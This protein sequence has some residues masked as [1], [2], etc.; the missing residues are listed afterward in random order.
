MQPLGRHLPHGAWGRNFIHNI[1]L[2]PFD[3]YVEDVSVFTRMNKPLLYTEEFR[4]RLGGSDPSAQFREFAAHTRTGEP[5]DSLLY[6]DA[7]T[8]LPGD[9]LTKV[10]RMTMAVGLEARTPLLDHK[11]IELVGRIPA[12]LK[13]K[14]LETKHLFKRAVAGLVP[15]EILNRPKQGFGI[16]LQHWINSEL[17]GRTRETLLDA[18][19]RERGYTD[20]AYVTLLLDEHERGRRDHA[21]ELWTLFMLELWHRA[22]VDVKPA[23]QTGRAGEPEPVVAVA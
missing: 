12:R 22:F 23:A 6:L 7:K 15:D 3:R 10:D 5:L 1:A 9:I 11:L 21:T 4:R 20:A 13:M 17:R 14:G 16:P 18:R 19:T 8:Y 2:D